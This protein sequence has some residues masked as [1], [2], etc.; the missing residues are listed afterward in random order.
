M[1]SHADERRL[2]LD[3]YT[4]AKMRSRG[5]GGE[6]AVREFERELTRRGVL[7]HVERRIRESR[8]GR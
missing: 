3:A 1:I 7:L 2:D 6:A 5:A 8:G 4:L